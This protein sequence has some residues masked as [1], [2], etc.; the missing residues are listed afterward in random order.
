MKRL[1]AVIRQAFIFV[2]VV[3]FVLSM[4]G[5]AVSAISQS[6]DSRGEMLKELEL[7]TDAVDFIQ[8]QYVREV[9]PKDLIYGAL[10]GM[11][12]DLD[13]HSQFLLPEEFDEL[14]I[15]T[16]GKFAGIGVEITMKDD[17]VTVITPI[18]DSPAWA[19]GLAPND[20]IVKIDDEVIKNFTLNDAVKKLRGKPGT[21]VRLV[22]WREKAGKLYSFTVKRTMID[23]KDIKEARIID[24]HI[25]YLR[26]VEFREG[27]P[28]ELDRVLKNLKAQGLKGLVIDLRNNPGGLLDQAIETTQRFLA[29]GSLIVTVRGRDPKETEEFKSTFNA[30]DVTTPMVLLVNEGSASGS[31]IMAGALQ[32]HR[33]A[34]LCGSTTFG[35]GSVQTV[36][37]LSDGSALKLT[38]SLYYTPSGRSIHDK[39]IKPDMEIAD[40]MVG[41]AAEEVTGDKQMIFESI[42]DDVPEGP[43]QVRPEAKV[44]NDKDDPPLVKAVDLLKN[45][46]VF[47]G[48][49]ADIERADDSEGSA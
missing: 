6:R 45:D 5:L 23:V 3:F 29:P 8:E 46:D 43:A 14:K 47:R 28:Q 15:D 26:I 20:R 34:V 32:D 16:E 41:D 42:G 1:I 35:K 25:G 17:L 2:C 40:A 33:R 11:V 18:E 10:S 12:S 19:A 4:L 38:T 48:T 27:T 7:F 39:G 24:D 37:P 31:E 44:N 30:A 49:V 9:K 36:L 21:T 22:V 13:P